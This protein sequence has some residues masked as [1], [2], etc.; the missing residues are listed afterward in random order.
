MK[1]L[2]SKM[3]VAQFVEDIV[4][5]LRPGWQLTMNIS[6]AKSEDFYVLT[7]IVE[8]SGDIVRASETPSSTTHGNTS[9]ENTPDG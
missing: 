2:L 4:G 7:A 3:A 5:T 9:P 6:P 1:S 8:S